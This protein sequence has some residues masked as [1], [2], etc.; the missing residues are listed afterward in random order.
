MPEMDTLDQLRTRI[1]SLIPMRRDEHHQGSVKLLFS[2]KD[3]LLTHNEFQEPERHSSN[4]N[5]WT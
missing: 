4:Y 3:E 2:S 5:L 1:A